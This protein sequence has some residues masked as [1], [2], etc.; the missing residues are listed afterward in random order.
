[1]PNLRKPEHRDPARLLTVAETAARLC[2]SKRAVWSLI[3]GGDLPV[4]RV[5]SRSVRVDPSDLAAYL[6]SV[7]EGGRRGSRSALPSRPAGG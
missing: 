3:S 2:V 7:R 1:M 5:G 6:A 4:H